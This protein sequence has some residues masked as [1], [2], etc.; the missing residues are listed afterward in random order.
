MVRRLFFRQLGHAKYLEK[1]IEYEIRKLKNDEDVLKL[2]VVSNYWK[3][4]Y[5]I[6]ILAN[7]SKP[8][9]QMEEDVSLAQ[10]LSNYH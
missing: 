2:L 9:T 6:K 5:P 7:F 3:R 10:H 1:L 4:F 8:V